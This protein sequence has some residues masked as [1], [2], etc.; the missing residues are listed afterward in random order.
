M[1]LP[2]NAVDRLF[3]RLL[4]TYGRDFSARWEGLDQGAVKSSWAHELAGFENHLK[5]IGWA[6]ENLP[7]RAPNVIEFRNLC[8]RAP[9]TE[10][11]R[12]ESPKVDPVIA[13]QVLDGLRGS[14]P[15]PA[16]R[17]DWARRIVEDVKAGMKRSP[18]VVKMA[19]DALGV[20]A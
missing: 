16:H 19:K 11:L 3:D 2:L 17:L 15:E 5:S 13:A 12:L 18:T 20:T 10:P 9:S 14:T 6:L 4:A 1:S 8:R 7:E